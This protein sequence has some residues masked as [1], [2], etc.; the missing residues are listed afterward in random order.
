MMGQNIEWVGVAASLLVLC[1]FLLKGEKQIRR[2]NILGA[3]T[4]VIYGILIKAFS[5]YVLNGALILI[6]IYKLNKKE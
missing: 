4:F 2:V 5:V 1:S 3:L 6:H